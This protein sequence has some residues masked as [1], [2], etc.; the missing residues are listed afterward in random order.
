[1]ITSVQVTTA[2]VQVRVDTAPIQIA[3]Q[4]APAAVQVAAPAPIHVQ[5]APSTLNLKLA[6]EQG[7]PGPRGLP[8]SGA[9]VAFEQVFAA[10]TSWVVNHNLG[11]YPIVTLLTTGGAEIE[12]E[13][14]HTSVDQFVVYFVTPLAGRV[15]CV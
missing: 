9:A 5:V 11:A 2:P 4:P 10:S 15:R 7:P 3:A 12:A 1:M 13:L 8:G 14:V 6:A